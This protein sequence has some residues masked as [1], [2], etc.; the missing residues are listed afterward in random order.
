MYLLTKKPPKSKCYFGRIDE[1]NA[2]AGL[3]ILNISIEGKISS[4]L[5]WATPRNQDEMWQTCI[6]FW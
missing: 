5:L 1:E 3:R 6:Q 4:R 2:G